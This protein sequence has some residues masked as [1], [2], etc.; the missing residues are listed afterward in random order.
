M[1][2]AFVNKCTVENQI[3]FLKISRSCKNINDYIDM[4][5]VKKKIQVI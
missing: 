3:N 2:S 1:P 4:Q 5:L